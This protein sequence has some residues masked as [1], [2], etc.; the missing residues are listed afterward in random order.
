MGLYICEGTLLCP[1]DDCE[2]KWT[3]YPEHIENGV[4]KICECQDEVCLDNGDTCSPLCVPW[5][6]GNPWLLH[7]DGVFKK[8]DMR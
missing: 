2:H 5:N 4:C 8:V 3:H 7:A 6:D 1:N